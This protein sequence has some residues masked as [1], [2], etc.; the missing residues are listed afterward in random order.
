MTM[1]NGLKLIFKW[2][3]ILKNIVYKQVKKTITHKVCDN[4]RFELP[5]VI[6]PLL[7]DV[8]YVTLVPL[9][10]DLLYTL[11]IFTAGPNGS[12]KGLSYSGYHTFQLSGHCHPLLHA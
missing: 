10:N 1:L 6:V 8:S 9:A 11:P 4:Y 2:G 12:P 3:I 5:H 7:V